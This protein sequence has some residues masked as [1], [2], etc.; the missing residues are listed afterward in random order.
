MDEP[1]QDDYMDE[2]D[3][4]VDNY[5]DDMDID[6]NSHTNHGEDQIDEGSLKLSHRKNNQFDD[7][8]NGLV[9]EGDDQSLEKLDSD[10]N[11]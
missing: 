5:Q 10:T 11:E 6:L 4:G 8:G 1:V 3:Y 2:D 9:G 7:I